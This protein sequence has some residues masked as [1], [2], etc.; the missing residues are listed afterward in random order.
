[1]GAWSGDTWGYKRYER[2]WRRGR[3]NQAGTCHDLNVGGD[4]LPWPGKREW[5]W[6]A[7]AFACTPTVCTCDVREAGKAYL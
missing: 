6:Q 7:H 2:R 1:M 5:L 3:K 4:G